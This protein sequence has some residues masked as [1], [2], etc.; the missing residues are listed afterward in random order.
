VILGPDGEVV[1]EI[2]SHSDVIGGRVNGT[3]HAE[4]RLELHVRRGGGV[5]SD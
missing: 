1:G 5:R 4:G 3:I 2:V